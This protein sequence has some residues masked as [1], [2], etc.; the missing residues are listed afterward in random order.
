MQQTRRTAEP[1]CVPWG[2]GTG[3]CPEAS[4]RRR[5]WAGRAGFLGRGSHRCA[6]LETGVSLRNRGDPLCASGRHEVPGWRGSRSPGPSRPGEDLGSRSEVSGE[7]W[8]GF[9]CY[10]RVCGGGLGCVKGRVGWLRSGLPRHPGQRGTVAAREQTGRR[11]RGTGREAGRGSTGT[12]RVPGHRPAPSQAGGAA[13]G[14]GVRAGVGEVGGGSRATGSGRRCPRQ[15]SGTVEAEAGEHVPSHGTSWE[16]GDSYAPCAQNETHANIPH[17][18][19]IRPG[20]GTRA[21]PRGGR[22]Q[23]GTLGLGAWRGELEPG[24]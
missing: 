22:C 21:G 10:V 2:T 19:S 1:P 16:S 13:D 23:L 14:H 24:A 5:D 11:V 3:R 18:P 12:G 8:A 15:S 20:P 7:A 6:G 9:R 4:G 17:P